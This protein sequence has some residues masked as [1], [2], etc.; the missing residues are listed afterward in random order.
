MR[1]LDM[2]LVIL[3]DLGARRADLFV[4]LPYIVCVGDV[5]FSNCDGLV[6]VVDTSDLERAQDPLAFEIR[7]VGGMCELH[8]V[9]RNHL[10]VGW[11]PCALLVGNKGFVSTKLSLS[12]QVWPLSFLNFFC[13]V[14]LLVSC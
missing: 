7:Y 5:V 8:C 9:V 2:C 6:H 13:A 11:S 12:D 10:C 1:C 4:W 14:C 3:S